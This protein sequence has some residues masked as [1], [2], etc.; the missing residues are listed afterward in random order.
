MQPSSL[1]PCII[2]SKI[3]E[4][5][6]FYVRYLGAKLSFDCGWYIN[7]EFGNGA[8]MQFMS[9]QLGQ[10]LCNTAGLSYNFCVGDVDSEHQ[11]LISS[12]IAITMP[13][14]DHPWGDRGFAI[15]DPN[16]IF[17]Y[18]Y[19]MRDPSPEYKQYYLP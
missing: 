19:S 6:D 1:S 9:P 3:Q 8:C 17:L 12:G 13:L 7:L 5:S 15:Q 14:E 18:M 11:L 16:G 2:S 4:S 10:T